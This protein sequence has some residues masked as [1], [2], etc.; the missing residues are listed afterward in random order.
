V[1]L[2]IIKYLGIIIL[3]LGLILLWDYPGRSQQEPSQTTQKSS[4]KAKDQFVGTWKLV[5]WEMQR[6]NG[7]KIEPPF[8][9]DA[10]GWIMYDANGHMCVQIMRSNRTKFSS[11]NLLEG[12]TPEEKKAA[13]EGYIAYCSTYTVNEEEG[14]V[15]HHIELSLFPNWLGMDQKRFFEFSGDRLTLRPPPFMYAGEQ[16]TARL[17]WERLK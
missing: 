11:D 9:R 13:Y 14:F 10:T 15:I 5:S 3:L 4:Q 7:E 17:T 16:V 12:G 1:S 2:K 6:S 8:G